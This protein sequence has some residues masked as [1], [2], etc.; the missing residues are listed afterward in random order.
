M[1]IDEGAPFTTTIKSS[2]FKLVKGESRLF[3]GKPPENFKIPEGVYNTTLN[4]GFE[5]LSING[6]RVGLYDALVGRALVWRSKA[7]KI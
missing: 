3:V 4:G 2:D 7:Y 1:T 5:Y 6:R